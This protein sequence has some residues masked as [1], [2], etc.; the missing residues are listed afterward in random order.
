MAIII[1][2][3]FNTGALTGGED[4]ETGETIRFDLAR[5]N[6]LYAKKKNG[7]VTK[8]AFFGIKGI[9]ATRQNNDL[10]LLEAKY[11]S[12]RCAVSKE[13]WSAITAHEEWG[14][15]KAACDG[16]MNAK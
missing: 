3:A 1:F 10:V 13:L 16:W 6:F 2:T 14:F 7:R 5:E 4:T 9:K 11:T 12:T 15:I 8:N